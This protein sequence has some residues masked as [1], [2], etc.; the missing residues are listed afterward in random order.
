MKQIKPPNTVPILTDRNAF[1]Q[2]AAAVA[3]TSFE[4]ELLKFSKG[5]YLAR[6]DE[7]IER[8]TEFVAH[9]S[10]LRFGWQKWEE[11][12]PVQHEMGYVAET[13]RPQR[14]SE[15]GDNDPS[16]WAVDAQGQPR[17]PWQ[18]TMHLPLTHR[19]TGRRF[20]F[21]T[22][23]KG[24][25]GAIRALAAGYG[26][27]I[28]ENPNDLPIVSL[29]VGS[30]RHRDYGKILVPQFD[31]IGWI[32]ASNV[33]TSAPDDPEDPAPAVQAPRPDPNGS[34]SSGGRS[35]APAADTLF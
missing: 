12:K 6:N 16:T 33:P 20:G 2:L 34:G 10:G 23:S 29:A 11:G 31:V 30:Y 22:S 28:R 15:L 1:E 35:S 21:T 26:G 18:L 25:F 8:G 14:R 27:R 24:G 5:D 19:T 17:D 32:D 4:G 7:V 13:Y 3:N 9:V